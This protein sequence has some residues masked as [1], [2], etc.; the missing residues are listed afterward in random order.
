MAARMNIDIC[1][2]IQNTQ[3]RHTIQPEGQYFEVNFL[4][5]QMYNNFQV[6]FFADDL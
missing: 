1:Q 3:S 4:W 2:L 5:L 6:Q